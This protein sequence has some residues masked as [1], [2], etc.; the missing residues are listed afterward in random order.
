MK[1]GLIFWLIVSLFSFSIETKAN[2]II[3]PSVPYFT[4][5]MGPNNQMI[6]TQTAYQPGGYLT[7]P[8]ALSRPE[9]MVLFNEHLF[10]V[11][12]IEKKVF[13]FN[14]ALAFL[15]DFSYDG[16]VLPKG[17]DV[18]AN[19]IYVADQGAEAVF[20]FDHQGQFV[21]DIKKPTEPIFGSNNPFTPL[22]ISVGPRG[23]MYVVGEGSTSGVIQ[24]SSQGDFLG[25]FGTNFTGNSWLE[26]LSDFLGVQYA[27]NT[28]S[29]ATNIKMDDEGYVYTVSPTDQKALKRFNIASVDTLTLDYVNSGLLAVTVNNL[30]NIVTLS[31]EGIITEYDSLGRL[32]FTFGGIDESGNQRF[33]LMVNPVD[34]EILNDNR[35]LILDQ[36][37]NQILIYV[38]TQFAQLIHQG[39]QS[40]NDGIYDLEIWNDVLS[41]NE[42]F[43]VAHQAIGQAHY[44]QFDYDLALYHFELANDPIGYS[45]AYWQ[46]RFTFLQTYLGTIILLLLTL[47]VSTI[48]YGKLNHRYHFSNVKGYFT[49]KINHSKPLHDGMMLFRVLRH[50]LDVFYQIKH[51]GAS[52]YKMAT[53]IYVIFV[54]TTVIATIL[55]SYLFSVTSIQSFFLLEHVLIYSGVLILVVFSNY[56]IATLNDGEGWF[57]NV[58]I[59][60]AYSLAPYILLSIPVVIS[61]YGFTLFESFIYQFLWFIAYGWSVILAIIM[62]KEIHGYGLKDLF[63]NILL[64]FITVG[65]L[66]LIIF[67]SF[68]LFN[69][70]IDYVIGLV[71]EVIIRVGF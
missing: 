71:R 41:L 33:G 57:K 64:T 53:G 9:D 67:I 15:D 36:G 40:F 23:N 29:S 31:N 38:P 52:S 19:Y 55:P 54:I 21:R 17:L 10:I 45:N 6:A 34:I 46:I 59:G 8:I 11:D 39:L 27:L 13:I 24:L 1:K 30:N 61:S 60:F 37:L 62:I 7:L 65:L 51:Q 42:M 2:D 5:T 22:K 25:Y 49:E 28:P 56:L 66:I 26:T 70:V 14:E 20:I 68:L 16:F 35:L 18:D 47:W 3:D 32:I 63:K 48:V 4:Y 50:P 58:Y 12:S 44:R 43:S 69:Q